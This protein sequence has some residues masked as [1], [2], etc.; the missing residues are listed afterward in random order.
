MRKKMHLQKGLVFVLGFSLLM[1]VGCDGA[2][3]REAKYLN[4]AQA[5]FDEGNY[6]KV[7]VELKNVLQINPKNVEAHYLT[8]QVAEQNQEWRK[9][10]G[11]LL[12]VIETKPDHYEAQIK[13]GKLFLFAKDSD[14]ALEKAELV[15]AIEPQNPDALALKATVHLTKQENSQAKALLQQA[16]EV[17]PGHYESSLLMIKILGDEKDL[18]GAKQVLDNALSAHPDKLKLSLI[19]LNIML[20]EKKTDEAEALYTVLIQQHPENEMLYYDLAKLYVVEKKIDEA[21]Q[22]LKNLVQQLPDK[23][24]PKFVLIDFLT[25]QRG[26]K[27]TEKELN[28]LISEY[29]DNFGFRFAKLT[30]YKDQP[31]KIQQILEQIVEDDKL[32]VSGI[33]ARNRLATFFSAKGEQ[34]KARQ[35]V[36]EVIE[37]DSKNVSALLFRAGQ[38]VQEQ[39]YG[40][41]IAD[42]RTVLRENPDSEQ[43]L[44]LLAVSQLKNNNIE[45]A[46]ESLEKVVFLNP[47]NVVALKDLARI[48]VRRQDES[49]AI[50]L[51]EKNRAL[52]KEDKDISIMLID[53]YG[54]RKE[55]EKAETIAQEML[56]ST[57][58]N[59]DEVPHYKLAQ[60]YLAQQKY[61]KAAEEFRKVLVTKPNAPDVMAGL[62]NSYLALNKDNEAE[63]LL[64]QTLITN[65]D[66]PAFLTMRAELH[67]QKKQFSDA[68]RLFKQ[69]VNKNPKVELGY[70]NLASVYLLQKQLDKA[71]AV[72]QQGHQVMPDNPNLLMQLGVLNT[73]TGKMEEATAAYEK[74]IAIVPDNQLALNNLAALLVESSDPKQVQRALTLVEPLIDSEHAAF[75]DTFG[76]VNYKNG[77][78]DEAL[79]ALE[80]MS[81][82]EGIIPEMHY[83]LGMVYATKGRHE[84]AKLELEKATEKNPSYK[85]VEQAK[86]EL[87]RLQS[88]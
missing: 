18:T 1:A 22:V 60:L 59:A 29:P 82:K 17:V 61:E 28:A 9:M 2:K 83:H 54:K 55:W 47:K 81:Q 74:L 80:E 57:D 70:K 72:F 66:N 38:L 23:D 56:Q 68:E 27:Q 84:E 76:W 85:G 32:G 26:V 62:V 58:E 4:K 75:L 24:Q 51:L 78:I 21:E 53:L 6:E 50:D 46:Q 42:A 44:L 41:A 86:A 25:R 69:V 20:L 8:A 5:Y 14:K 48:K 13:L 30:L 37:L 39:K 71:I 67:R 63:K 77:K 15:L 35:L 16:L 31:D 79:A 87:A 36:E 45:L 73:I 7:R 33:E 64:D 34:E 49:G 43:A 88:L 11:N 3:D 40:D 52:F 10:Y 65:P 19:K 12:A